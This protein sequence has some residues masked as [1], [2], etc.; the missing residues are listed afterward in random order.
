MFFLFALNKFM[1]FDNLKNPSYFKPSTSNKRQKKNKRKLLVRR[2]RVERNVRLN[3][4]RSKS[5]LNATSFVDWK[6]RV[7]VRLKLNATHANIRIVDNIH[8]WFRP[9]SSSVQ[10][11]ASLFVVVHSVV[12]CRANVFFTFPLIRECFS[13]YL[14]SSDFHFCN[15]RRNTVRWQTDFSEIH[16]FLLE[17]IS[18]S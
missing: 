2:R 7:V 15:V 16:R 10:S 13:F 17:S 4:S 9:H 18:I 11:A 1:K 12:A 6:R 8:S 14:C 3:V 5:Q